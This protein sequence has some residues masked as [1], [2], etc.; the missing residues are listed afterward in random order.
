LLN[1]HFARE[2]KGK[3]ILRFDDTNPSKEKQE[4][5]D[6]IIEDCKRLDII[7]DVVT[8]TSD[9]FEKLQAVMEAM[10][11]S[12]ECY[13]DNT[14]KEEFSELKHAGKP[15]KCREN[16]VDQNLALWKQLLAGS[17]EGQK[18]VV[19]GRMR[20]DDTNLCMRDSVFYR[21][22]IDV[23]HHRYGFQ[24]K[25]Y[26]M[27]DF[28][29]PVV[30]MLEGVS[31]ALRTSE[32]SDRDV[33]YAWVQDRALP[34]VKADKK[35]KLAATYKKTYMY[36]FSKT[37]FKYTILS[38]RKLGW[39]VDNGHVEAWSDPRF[40][41]VQGILRRG[42]QVEALRDFVKTQGATKNTVLMDWD[43]IW[44]MNADALDK[45]VH[46]FF[47]VNKQDSVL[48]KIKGLKKG[49]ETFAAPVLLSRKHEDFGTKAMWYSSEVL[50]Q[51]DDVFDLA[52][53]E[54]ITLQWWGEVVVDK[55][56]RKTAGAGRAEYLKGKDV[57]TEIEATLNLAGDFKKNKK[58]FH[59]V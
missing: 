39:F 18:C 14:E 46:R 17:E 54:K 59:W 9:H 21:T 51:Q 45:K 43:K 52:E 32:Y 31:H 24:Y 56:I 53:G 48:M 5:E 58:K 1:N 15:S 29:C 25:A 34:I 57:V 2:F 26:P 47:A 37:Q 50:L 10:I 33:Q 3:L 55:V 40:P 27:Y 41:T 12:G 28:A 36:E 30:D 16:T 42:M 19:R 22:K 35:D 49:F 4:F 38:K 7:P 13:V 8:H 44:A 20:P 23:P 6:S 11:K